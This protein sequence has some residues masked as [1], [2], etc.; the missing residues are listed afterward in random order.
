MKTRMTSRRFARIVACVLASFSAPACADV[1][2]TP[3]NGPTCRDHSR[4]HMGE[5]I[6]P[7][8]GGAAAYFADEGNMAAVVLGTRSGAKDVLGSSWQFRGAG[9]VFGD[10][11]EWHV[12]D[13]RPR[14]AV[15]RVW[16]TDTA[17]DGTDKELQE[18]AVFAINQKQ[19]CFMTAVPARQAN[20]NS[21]ASKEAE[22]VSG[23]AC[24]S[25]K[26]E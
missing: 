1:I 17:A 22:R 13:G 21:I 3:T 19:S 8:P 25:L 4:E 11:I 26:P 10:K 15:L 9:K 24:P 6:C 16:R 2:Y 5:W 18:L 7:G 14:A 12:V 20:A 23:L